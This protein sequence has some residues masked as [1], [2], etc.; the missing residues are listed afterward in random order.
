MRNSGFLVGAAV[1]AAAAVYL[2]NNKRMV[3]STMNSLGDTV[4][5]AKDKVV[6]AAAHTRFGNGGAVRNSQDSG[7]LDR[8]EEIV[9]KEPH[10]QNDVDQIM[11]E[12]RY[13]HN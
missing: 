12:N 5:N 4:Q 7:G 6:G 11:K 3:Y 9:H 8:V 10:L 1:G 2:M 13:P